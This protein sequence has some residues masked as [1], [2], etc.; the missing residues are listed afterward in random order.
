MVAVPLIACAVLELKVT[1][2]VP[3]VTV[4]PLLVQLLA[5]EADAGNVNIEPALT[6]TILNGKGVVVPLSVVVPPKM[7]VPVPI[8]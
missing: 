1:V 6:C 3:G 5:T 2:P 8:V 7:V 4:P